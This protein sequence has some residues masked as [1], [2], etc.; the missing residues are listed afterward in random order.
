MIIRLILIFSLLIPFRV[1]SQENEKPLQK[2]GS[3]QNAAPADSVLEKNNAPQSTHGK[4]RVSWGADYKLTGKTSLGSILGHD[5]DSFY[6]LKFDGSGSGLQV[7]I[8]R[9]GLKTLS[10]VESYPISLT[11]NKEEELKVRKSFMIDNFIWIFSTYYNRKTDTLYCYSQQFNLRGNKRGDRKIIDKRHAE[12]RKM[13]GAYDFV[14]S[15]DTNTVLVVYSPPVNK[16]EF[17][18]RKMYMLG[19]D[20]SLIWAQNIEI[21]HPSEYFQVIRRV[22]ADTNRVYILGVAYTNKVNS[23]NKSRVKNTG[24]YMVFAYNQKEKTLNEA[25]LSL[26]GKYITSADLTYDKDHHVYVIGLLSRSRSFSVSGAFYVMVDI[27]KQEVIKKGFSVFEKDMIRQFMSGK[28]EVGAGE[29]NSFEIRELYMDSAGQ[30]TLIA[31]QYYVTT[32]TYTDPRTGHVMYTYYYHYNDIMLIRFKDDGRIKWVKRIP[33]EQIS[34]D[35]RGYYSSYAS[36]FY[37]GKLF[38]LFNDNPKNLQ[39]NPNGGIKNIW[40]MDDPQ[41]AVA[42]FITIEGDQQ[43]DREVLFSSKEADYIFNPNI[44]YR[45]NERS[46]LLLA[47]GWKSYRFVRVDD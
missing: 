14:L 35:D 28:K 37:K 46:L 13:V 24:K 40:A 30:A 27:D 6:L 2:S 18:D 45:I 39:Y 34:L 8:G 23:S 5:S 33:K 7:S 38:I 12:N 41:K 32:T 17:E 3:T 20:N 31:E 11:D 4:A 15:I 29:L 36:V 43:L 1:F 26:N 21:S 25:Q 47:Q 10:E 22:V 9:F 42:V 19:K 44:I 16:Y